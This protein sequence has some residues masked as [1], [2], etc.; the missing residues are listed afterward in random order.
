MLEGR[1][2]PEMTVSGNPGFLLWGYTVCHP[3]GA[4]RVHDSH[5]PVV[6]AVPPPSTLKRSCGPVAAPPPPPPEE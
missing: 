4:V 6:L 5:D 1:C 2:H 3:Y